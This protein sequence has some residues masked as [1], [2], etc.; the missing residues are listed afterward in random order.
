MR[1]KCTIKFHYS[2][3]VRL[4]LFFQQNVTYK[5]IYSRNYFQE[6]YLKKLLKNT[7]LCLLATNSG[8]Y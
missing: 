3:T 5:R 6:N 2:S 1:Y 8:N 7:A 4:C